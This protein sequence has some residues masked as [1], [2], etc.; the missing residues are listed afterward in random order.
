MYSL[1]Q[2]WNN[3]LY[4]HVCMHTENARIGETVRTYQTGMVTH[5]LYLWFYGLH[6]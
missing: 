2:C 4:I 5:W 6:Y 1:K 3:V